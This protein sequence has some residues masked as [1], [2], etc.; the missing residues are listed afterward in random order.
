MSPNPELTSWLNGLATSPRTCPVSTSLALRLQV[1]KAM[2]VTYLL[3]FNIIVGQ[4]F[5]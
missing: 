4:A 5:H 2:P 1:C 3:I